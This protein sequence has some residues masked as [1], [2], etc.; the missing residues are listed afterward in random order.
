MYR[1]NAPADIAATLQVDAGAK[2]QGALGMSRAG[3]DCRGRPV[4]SWD[5]ASRNRS[6]AIS[7]PH[8]PSANTV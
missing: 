8:A 4:R 6:V 5:I 7:V 1:P 2:C 3:R